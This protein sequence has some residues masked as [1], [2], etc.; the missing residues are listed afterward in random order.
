M[1]QTFPKN[2]RIRKPHEFELV[3]KS[4]TYHAGNLIVIQVARNGL[5]T[6]RLG[7]AISRAVGNAVVRNRWKRGLREA[8]RSCRERL[9]AGYDFVIRPRRGA[10]FDSQKIAAELARDLNKAVRRLHEKD[11]RSQNS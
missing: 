3:R 7:L 4:D 2:V 8:F 6:S 1:N 11:S 10:T 5:N 9:P